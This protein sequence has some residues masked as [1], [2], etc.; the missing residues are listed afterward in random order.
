M[1]PSI[2]VVS[3][4]NP[5][6]KNVGSWI[7]NFLLKATKHKDVNLPT[8]RWNTTHIKRHWLF[9]NS[10]LLPTRL[11]SIRMASRMITPSVFLSLICLVA[12]VSASDESDVGCSGTAN[13]VLSFYGLW[14]QDRHPSTS[15]PASQNYITRK[16]FTVPFLK[17]KR[18]KLKLKVFLVG[19]SV[20]AEQRS[21]VNFA[22]LPAAVNG[23]SPFW[24]AWTIA[25]IIRMASGVD[26]VNL[27]LNKSSLKCT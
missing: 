12:G 27:H 13:Y 9:L 7:L 1:S 17:Y 26:D 11:H 5:L 6:K 15:H 22:Y 4:N 8:Y 18:L 10:S 23:K 14:K 25:T 20:A 21:L 16:N 3:H 24:R 19:H 2:A